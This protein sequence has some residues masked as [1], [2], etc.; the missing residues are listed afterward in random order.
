M[1]DNVAAIP[2]TC[3]LIPLAVLEH[4]ISDTLE[5][6]NELSHVTSYRL[7][8]WNGKRSDANACSSKSHV[9]SYRLRYWNPVWVGAQ[10]N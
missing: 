5:C 2:V 3:D 9:T 8:Y 10:L 4:L 7:R 6:I 1:F